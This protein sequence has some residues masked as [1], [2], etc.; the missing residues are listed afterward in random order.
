MKSVDFDVNSSAVPLFSSGQAFNESS[1]G[2]FASF[3]D[4]VYYFN[5]I[6]LFFVIVIGIVGNS[7]TIIVFLRTRSQQ[8]RRARFF[9]ISL[10]ISDSIYL[11]ILLCYWLEEMRIYNILNRNI[12][13]QTTVY[14]TYVAS[15][16]SSAIVLAFTVQRVIS[17]VFPF[18]QS[19]KSKSKVAFFLMLLFAGLFYS[20]A[21]WGYY[22]EKTD[23]DENE[24]YCKARPVYENLVDQLNLV[25][26]VF[27]FCI[28]F[29]GILILN[30]VIIKK[31]KDSANDLMLTRS[32][33]NRRSVR[34]HNQSTNLIFSESSVVDKKIKSV[35]TARGRTNSANETQCA[36][37]VTSRKVTKMLLVI[38]S[39]FFTL[40]LPYHSYTVYLYFRVSS[41]PSSNYTLAENCILT[42]AKQVFNTS[43]ACNFFLYS[44]T[45]ATFRVELK[46]VYMEAI[47]CMIKPFNKN[48]NKTPTRNFTLVP[49]K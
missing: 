19:T 30:L 23:D 9:L 46:R 20:F 8:F 45:G 29:T 40:N 38:S 24:P 44:I 6:Y 26:S 12:I 3:C 18:A 41:R 48:F 31:L 37:S 49:C 32:K 5:K 35:Q 27:T 4:A 15:F 36:A 7:I 25:D 11:I 17:I 34:A 2:S 16:M 21:F 10:A 39:V 13:C 28:P 14:I 33:N 42:V 1:L 47:E 22:I 43:F